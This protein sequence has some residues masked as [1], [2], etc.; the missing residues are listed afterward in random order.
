MKKRLFTNGY[1]RTVLLSILAACIIEAVINMDEVRSAFI[2]QK[3][4]A[5]TTTTIVKDT[6]ND[7]LKVP[8][9]ISGVIG[10]VY[11]AFFS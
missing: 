9:R 3:E 10:K 4:T 8:Q 5:K 7:L 2:R 1:A 6:T 11:Y